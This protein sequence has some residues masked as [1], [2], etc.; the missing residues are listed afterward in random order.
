MK[1]KLLDKP[2]FYIYKIT[3]ETGETY[4]GSHIEYKENDGYICSSK[5]IERHPELKIKSREILFYLPSLEQMN[6]ME[7]I[8]IIS[9]KCNSDNNVNGNYGNWMYN[10]HSNLDC[11]WNKGLKMSKE[12]SEMMSKKLSE[13]LICV[14]TMEIIENHQISSHLSDVSKGTRKTIG[15]RHYRKITK[16]EKENIL[17]GNLEETE[18]LNTAFMIELYGEETFFYCQEYNIA[19]ENIAMLAGMLATNPNEIKKHFGESFFGITI[20]PLSGTEIFSNGIKV[21]KKLQNIR[22]PGRYR[23]IETG[24]IFNSLKEAKA[25][26]KG[27]IESVVTGRRKTAGGYHWEKI[28]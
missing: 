10:F 13:P 23:N 26:Y 27:H 8:C 17:K 15:G 11:P 19:F 22:K 9:D 16:E 6:I 18:K 12:F 14:E 25:K 7:T 24:E 20:I 21:I 1:G 4:I 28:A 2:R 5:Y 3:L